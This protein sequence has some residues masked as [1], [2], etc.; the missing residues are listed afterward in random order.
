MNSCSILGS[1]YSNPAQYQA[2]R[3]GH[4]RL[5]KLFLFKAFFIRGS[6]LEKSKVVPSATKY[7][8]EEVVFYKCE[9]LFKKREKEFFSL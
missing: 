9:N 1:I 6:K 5:E 4:K 7:L 8:K 3:P 2:M